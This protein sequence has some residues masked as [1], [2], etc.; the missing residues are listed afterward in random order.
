LTI[1][2]PSAGA[3]IDTTMDHAVQAPITWQIHMAGG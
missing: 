3:I 1:A 2:R